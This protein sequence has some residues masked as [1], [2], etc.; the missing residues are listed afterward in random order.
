MEDSSYSHMAHRPRPSLFGSLEQF[1]SSPVMAS[2]VL[3]HLVLLVRCV[4]VA[5]IPGS[6]MLPFSTRR[7]PTSWA[8]RYIYLLKW[9]NGFRD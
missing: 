3:L 7:H 6:A 5:F 9:D 8:G 1:L 4:Q 2:V